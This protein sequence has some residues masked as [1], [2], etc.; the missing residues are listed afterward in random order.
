M[1]YFNHEVKTA[2]HLRYH[3]VSD[4]FNVMAGMFERVNVSFKL[5]NLTSH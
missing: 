1:L 2:Y 5:L 4:E 3:S